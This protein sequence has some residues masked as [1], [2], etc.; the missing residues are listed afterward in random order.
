MP[1]YDFADQCPFCN[2][3]WGDCLHVRLLIEW[4]ADALMREAQAELGGGA[5]ADDPLLP[6]LEERIAPVRSADSSGN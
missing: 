6:D 3:P 4:E 2:A 5:S 1:G